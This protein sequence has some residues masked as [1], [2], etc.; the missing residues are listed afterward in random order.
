MVSGTRRFVIAAS[1][2]V[3]AAAAGFAIHLWF[4]RAPA[5]AALRSSDFFHVTLKDLH[6]N[7]QPLDQW[8]GKVLVVNFWATWCE[9]CR[10]EI[11]EFIRTQD[12]Y[13]SRGLQFVGIAID[14]PDKVAA[15]VDELHI[16]YPVLVG[17]LTAMEL[18][19]GLGNRLGALPF[20]AVF[21]RH[22]KLVEVKTGLLDEA[23]LLQVVES[24]IQQ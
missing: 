3:V 22:A 24:L 20:T 12:R 15:F 18:A 19:R 17:D 2:A 16:N 14:Q 10:K 21:D 13:G 1:V 6:G 8:R 9:P 4:F 5:E 7:P 11:P 23:R